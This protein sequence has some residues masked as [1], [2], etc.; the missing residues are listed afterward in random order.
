MATT[1]PSRP[2]RRG[3]G[4][5]RGSGGEATAGTRERIVTA[6]A[7]LFAERGFHATPM[8]GVAVA[9][10][11]SQTGLLHHFASKEDLLAAVLEQRD[12]RDVESLSARRA[13]PARGWE[14]FDDMVELVRL[15]AEREALVRLFTNLAGEAVDPTHP[16]HD[17]LRRHH[18]A[19]VASLT[20]ALTEAVA[21]GNADP[22]VPGPTLARQFVALMDGLQLQWLM[23]PDEVDMAA[24]LAAHLSAVRDRW[25]TA[26]G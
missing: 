22:A 13:A 10:G 25:A 3:R 24:D 19:A 17:W 16:G 26:A 11:L 23:A 2:A 8:T 15:N 6:A 5:P 4:R 12:T 21:D 14:V 9:S 7:E 18:A 20:H 1:S